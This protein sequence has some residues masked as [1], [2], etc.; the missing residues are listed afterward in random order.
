MNIEGKI[1]NR[2][3][4]GKIRSNLAEQGKSVVFTNGC[5]DLLHRGHVE[6]LEKASNAGDILIIGLNSDQS[7]NRLKGKGRPIMPQ[8]DRAYILASLASVDYVSIFDEDTP[9]DLIKVVKPD[10]L[11]KGSDYN[12]DEI[13]GRDFV[14]QNGGKV[15]TIP[16]VPERSTTDIINKIKESE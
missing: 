4:L 6:Y 15:L 1:K 8:E 10:V 2:E 12:L 9:L 5:F 11:I 3:D 16:L 7:T 14:E 13:V